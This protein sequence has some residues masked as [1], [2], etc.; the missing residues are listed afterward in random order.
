MVECILLNLKFTVLRLPLSHGSGR[1]YFLGKGMSVL[2]LVTFLSD[3]QRK[4]WRYWQILQKTNRLVTYRLQM[5][6]GWWLKPQLMIILFQNLDF[7]IHLPPVW[8]RRSRKHIYIWWLSSQK[9][10]IIFLSMQQVKESYWC[11]W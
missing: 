6:L 5:Q 10:Q 11:I 1:Y 7:P 2:S 4:M 9:H 8:L 3:W